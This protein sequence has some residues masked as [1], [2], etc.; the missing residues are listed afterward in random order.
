MSRANWVQVYK[1]EDVSMHVEV[2]NGLPFLHCE[3]ETWNRRKYKEYINLWFD[4]Q[5]YLKQEG[6]DH[7]FAWAFDP[8][9]KHFAE[10]FGFREVFTDEADQSL[11]FLKY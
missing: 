7:L 9:I 4:I 6:I 2:H 8:K 10:M 3:I 11:L 1:D 5:D